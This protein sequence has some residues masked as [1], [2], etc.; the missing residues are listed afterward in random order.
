VSHFLDVFLFQFCLR[1]LADFWHFV[2]LPFGM[3]G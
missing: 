2:F 3:K 1:L